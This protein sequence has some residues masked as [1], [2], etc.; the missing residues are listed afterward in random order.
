[1]TTLAEVRLAEV[2][3]VETGPTEAASTEVSPTKICAAQSE[4]SHENLRRS[5]GVKD[6]N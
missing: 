2:R 3:L 6:V 1:M 5:L 4:V